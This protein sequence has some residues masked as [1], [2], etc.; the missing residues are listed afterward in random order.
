[1]T[2]A[3]NP[4]ADSVTTESI[5]P[6]DFAQIFSPII[7]SNAQAL[8]RHGNVVVK[9]SP[10]CGKSMLLTL[11]KPETRLAYAKTNEDF[12]IPKENRKFISAGI[13]LT[14]V[15][16][17]DIGNRLTQDSGNGN[18]AELALYFA[19]FFNYLL[20]FDLL[21]SI[22]KFSHVNLSSIREEIGLSNSE[23]LLNQAALLIKDNPCWFGYLNEVENFATLSKK[24]EQRIIAYRSYFNFN[25]DTLPQEVL[26]SKTAAGVPTAAIAAILKDVGVISEDT[27]VFIRVDQVDELFYL[28]TR[29]GLG[30]IF[31]QIINKAVAMRDRRVSYRIGVRGYAWDSE[32]LVFGTGSKLEPERDYT[33]ID[34]EIILR[35]AESRKI[36]AFPGLAEDI[37][38][39]RL[40][41]HKYYV[42]NHGGDELM[43]Q[44]FGRPIPAED[45]A[46]IYAGRS[47][48]R[49]LD[50][51]EAWPE[52][53]KDY[54]L[55]LV[56]V[57]PL[58]AK[59]GEAWARQKGKQ[60]TVLLNFNEPPWE[61]KKS[62]WW[63]KERKEVALMQIA[64]RTAQRLEWSGAQE[65]LE[66]SGGNTLVFITLCRHI[67]QAWLR[68]TGGEISTAGLP[69]IDSKIQATGIY[70]ASR[71]WFEKIIP[72]SYN[73]NSRCRLLQELGVWFS[74]TLLNDRAM[75]NPGNN[76]MSLTKE[77]L[78][79]DKEIRKILSLC[80]DFG[81]LIEVEHTTK[82]SDKK[83][84]RKWYLAPILSPYFKITHVHTKEPIYIKISD[85]RKR[86]E[87][88]A[89]I[90]ETPSPTKETKNVDGN[91]LSLF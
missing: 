56:K 7:V 81:D 21:K 20:A 69:K 10:G 87:S 3:I 80:V 27:L 47:P 12:P 66:L 54:L 90:L 22:V 88:A 28:E 39:R 49:I 30:N 37:F 86:I 45:L 23:D 71:S 58:S 24:I 61:E 31:R 29:Y 85:L 32:S 26:S 91:Q 5:A 6:E 15:G 75:S 1:M 18:A 62:R 52:N 51:D 14:R 19:D 44:V 38:K 67:W 42:G 16:A 17:Q 40:I 9:G 65:I 13:N 64:S 34:L 55:N 59:F 50:F 46:R 25:T 33:E 60:D 11:L 36:W 84:R 72:Q 73:G 48:E 2:Q 41:S 35:R 79:L 68:S 83:Q 57:D 78:R 8:F 63:R 74:K 77:E 89:I 43:R 53:W 70:D 76:G 82:L 4:F